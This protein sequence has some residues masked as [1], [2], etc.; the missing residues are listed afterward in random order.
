MA[1]QDSSNRPARHWL[2][3]ERLRVYP[4]LFLFAYLLLGLGWVAMAEQG[5]DRSGK[6]LGYDFIT[7]WSASKLA[8]EG[9]PVAAY[10]LRRIVAVQHEAVPGIRTHH[11]WHYP[12]TFLLLVLPLALL[13]YAASFF[14]FVGLSLAAYA[15]VIR[16][17]LPQP[18]VQAL[19]FAFPGV[20]LSAFHGQ[21]AFL[22]T[23]LMGAALWNLHSRPWLAGALFALL[24][25]KPHLGLL[26]PIAL[27]CG[28]HWRALLSAC[29]CTL[30]FL[31]LSLGVLGTGTLAAFL[32]RLPQVGHW[33]ANNQL[34]QE[35]MP[36]MFAGALRLGAD[37]ALAYALQAAMAAFAMAG[38]IW[39]WRGTADRALKNAGLCA[40]SLMVSPYLFDYDLAWLALPIA[41]FAAYAL[42][43][44]WHVG[45]RNL[46][47]LTW[48]APL[49]VVPLAQ[50]MRFGPTPLL[51][52]ALFGVILRRAWLDEQT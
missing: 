18:G 17:I 43:R 26:I 37:P 47:A 1:A 19:L 34:P 22:T 45:E 20:M 48:L 39:L 31:G 11:P 15:S 51:I 46:L 4:R 32:G 50:A 9:E 27:V 42:Q 49:L 8:L 29:L 12:P 44:G 33:V 28:A 40:A 6:P 7:F 21:N 36:T 5:V 3:A 52:A 24:T 2:D 10:D 30:G 35:K 25:I 23:A 38:V 41:W 13:P 14:A 16:R